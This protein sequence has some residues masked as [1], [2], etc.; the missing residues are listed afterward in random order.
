MKPRALL[1]GTVIRG[2]RYG[3]TLGYP[4]AN[5]DHRYFRK[6]PQPKGVYAALAWVG[7]TR[8]DAL[9]VVGVPGPRHS[10]GKVEV[11]LLAFNGSLYGKKI[12][13]LLVE[14]IRS[15][16]R[17]RNR[18]LLVDRIRKD[19]VMAR[20]IIRRY[21]HD[22][23]KKI[24]S[25]RR[26]VALVQSR[27]GRIRKLLRPGISEIAVRDGIERIMRPYRMSFPTIVASGPNG[28][29][30][31]HTPTS[32]KL[33]G[34]DGVVVDFGIVVNGF[35]TDLSRTFFISRRDYVQRMRYDAVRAAQTIGIAAVRPLA[36]ARAIDEQV[37]GS[38]RRC[39]LGGL[40]MH[41]AGHGVGRQIHEPPR[42]GQ[43]SV[44]LILPGDI[45]TVEPGIYVPG[46]GG[47]RI[48]DMVLVTETG[49]EVLT[50]GIPSTAAESMVY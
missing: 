14:K 13:A 4:T 16:E 12:T 2:E 5:L 38:L 47:I 23:Q 9:G 48:E 41:G 43:R 42:L 6:N 36:N 34:G 29:S 21:R 8:Y 30:M 18:A 32:R 39:R 50:K 40:F 49:A 35:C 44:D 19:I 20:R 45:V 22:E 1:H 27:F 17:Y 24:T 28:A 15:L 31:H 25:I 37:R 3:R 7:R 10:D 11:H 26:G 46:W 33:A